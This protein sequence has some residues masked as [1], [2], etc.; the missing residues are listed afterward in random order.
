[1]GAGR[2]DLDLEEGVPN[3]L[4]RLRLR[5]WRRGVGHAI[6][7]S[8]GFAYGGDNDLLGLH[9]VGLK[10]LQGTIQGGRHLSLKLWGETELSG[11]EKKGRKDT[12]GVGGAQRRA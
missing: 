3:Q 7:P 6:N 1:M 5:E 10:L 2:A 11:G 4:R 12:E 8:R 9:D